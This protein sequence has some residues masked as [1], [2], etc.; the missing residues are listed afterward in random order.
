MRL[1]HDSELGSNGHEIWRFVEV[2]CEIELKGRI[3]AF[4]SA[5]N[6]DFDFTR[7]VVETFGTIPDDVAIRLLSPWLN[8]FE[9]IKGAENIIIRIFNLLQA[10][11]PREWSSATMGRYP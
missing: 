1:A 3:I 9:T 4:P 6:T 2:L 8:L 5:S 7:R 11:V 10:S